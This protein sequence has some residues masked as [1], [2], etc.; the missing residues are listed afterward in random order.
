M[1]NEHYIGYNALFLSSAEHLNIVTAITLY[2][3]LRVRCEPKFYVH[4]Y[5]EDGGSMFLQN[6]LH[7]KETSTLKVEAIYYYETS[8]TSYD[9]T[10]SQPRRPK[11]ELSQSRRENLKIS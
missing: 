5:H 1:I 11:S 4:F 3:Y 7:H 9:Y 10:V 6:Y 2:P 8:I